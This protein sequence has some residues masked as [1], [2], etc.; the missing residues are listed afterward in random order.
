MKSGRFF[1]AII[2]SGMV[3]LFFQ[4]YD[5][6]SLQN[7]WATTS[8]AYLSTVNVWIIWGVTCVVFLFP[9]ELFHYIGQVFYFVIRLLTIV[10]VAIKGY[11]STLSFDMFWKKKNKAIHGD[12]QFMGR[13][14]QW[15]YYL[16]TGVLFKFYHFIMM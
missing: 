3:V 4:Q 5:F 12:A 8:T 9:A 7:S 6:G 16:N 10:G 13:W 2:L 1:G 15:R 14:K 11:G